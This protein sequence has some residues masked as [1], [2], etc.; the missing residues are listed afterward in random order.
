MGRKGDCWGGDVEALG[1]SR[2]VKLL[3]LVFQ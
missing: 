1:C 2:M 3:V